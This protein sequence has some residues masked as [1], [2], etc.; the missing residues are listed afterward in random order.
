MKKGKMEEVLGIKYDLIRMRRGGLKY[1]IKINIHNTPPGIG[2]RE[3][4]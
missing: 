1:G 4:D 2:L 3:E